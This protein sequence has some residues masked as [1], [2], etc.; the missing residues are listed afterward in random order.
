MGTK[1]YSSFALRAE[2][3]YHYPR[4][5]WAAIGKLSVRDLGSLSLGDKNTTGFLAQGAG[6]QRP[7]HEGEGHV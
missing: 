6:F 2:I 3:G 5:H 1:Y 4:D 7:E